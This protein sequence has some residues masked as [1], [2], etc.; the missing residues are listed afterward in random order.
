MNS[1]SNQKIILILLLLGAYLLSTGI[2]YAFF[3]SSVKDKIVSLAPQPE[4]TKTPAGSMAFDASLPK[5]ETC[6]I[7]GVK[8]SKQQ[9][10][11]WEKHR[12]LG[13][14]IE[15]HQ[16]SRPQSGLSFADVIYE[17]VAEGG[18]TRFLAVYHC[19]DTEFVG[20][21]RSARTYF[22]DWISEYGDFPLYV[23]VGG[24]NTPGPAD[25]ISQI[26]KY[27]WNVYNDLNQFSIGF[28]VFWRDYDRLGRTVA[29]EHTM[30]STTTRLWDF[31]KEERNLT[32]VNED[33]DAW[34][35][36]FVAYDFKEDAKVSER[37]ESQTI[38]LKFW[39]GYSAY[40]VEWSYDKT[41][42]E[43][44]RESGGQVHSDKNNGK[45]LVAK[46]V[47]LLFMRES[48]AN[49]G[50]D[51]GSHL[52]Y[53]TIGTGKAKIYIDGKEISGTWR[54]DKRESRTL[55]FDSSGNPIEFNRGTI[56]FEILPLDA[57]VTVK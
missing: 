6:P 17:A 1:S 27:G 38:E 15:N 35:E 29:T 32:N 24:A 51:K 47:V 49:D 20:P 41:K 39:T 40:N 42:N 43:Y 55:I 25:A 37:S 30:Y 8:Y 5:T 53:K 13:V 16:E 45:Q 44:L 19:Q 56:W 50:Y 33:G 21:V 7:N 36:N 23:H 34:D 2:S 52:L 26:S 10:N 4:P 48:V 18:I 31:A 11:W 46:N 57:D 22:L 54:K 14:M 9:K 28:P 3:S 12:P